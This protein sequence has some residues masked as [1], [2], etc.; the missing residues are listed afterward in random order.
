MK[1]PLRIILI[2]SC[3]VFCNL[4]TAQTYVEITTGSYSQNFNSVTFGS[5]FINPTAAPPAVS[6][7]IPGW[8]LNN[9][10]AWLGQATGLGSNTGGFY[11]YDCSG[12]KF[13]G[14]RSSNSTTNLYYGVVLRNNTGLTIRSIK[15]SYR[16]YQVSLASNGNVVNTQAF[17]YAVSGTIPAVTGG[18]SFTGLDFN[19]LQ[20]TATTG[21]T[22]IT[23]YGCSQARD[24]S[25]CVPVTINN[26][27]YLLLRWYESNDANNDHHM[28]IDDLVVD[29]DLTGTSCA[30]ILPIELT[31]FTAYYHKNEV[32]LNWTT[33]T[34]LN[35]DLFIVERSTDA[36]NFEEICRVKG[37][38]N[39]LQKKSYGC[40]DTD[41]KNG[42]SYY[43][44]KQVDFD[45]TFS[46]SRIETVSIG[47]DKDIRV[48]PNPNET[49]KLKI[50]TGGAPASINVI[51]A[52]GKLILQIKSADGLTELDLLPFGAGVY[53]VSVVTNDKTVTTK[54]IYN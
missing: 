1:N 3:I 29:F 4:I 36:L 33:A 32:N 45:R 39:S 44:L 42:V 40:T 53:M 2:F 28:G 21:G 13:F 12:N 27:Q 48:Y 46:Y 52:M 38:G 11:W 16:G 14:G 49:G 15:V 37:A 35:N 34:E 43:R 9:T 20:T 22:Q 17:A 41:P 30:T 24:I 47:L 54:V 51:D 18:T 8:Y 19:Q 31:D 6:G 10:G 25:A 23:W 26:G 7:T 5:S 50:A